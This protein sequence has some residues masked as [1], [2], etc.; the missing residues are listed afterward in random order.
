MLTPPATFRLAPLLSS[1]Y[2][3]FDFWNTVIAPATPLRVKKPSATASPEVDVQ[4]K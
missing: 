4:S 2:S 3:C 1:A